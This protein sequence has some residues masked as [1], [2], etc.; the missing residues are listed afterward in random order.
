[1]YQE[2]TYLYRHETRPDAW[3]P[4]TEGVQHSVSTQ[5]FIAAK[6]AESSVW[7]IDT[8]SFKRSWP[9]S[10]WPGGYPLYYIVKDG[11][12]LCPTC[13]NEE[14][15]RTGDPDD[16]QFFIVGQDVNYE[17]NDMWCD[18]CNTKIPAAYSCDDEGQID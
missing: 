17:D 2:I 10:A 9:S 16:G 14:F 12:L 3:Y 7:L 5:D 4:M 15:H 18:H 8:D 1:M 6:V 13:A 11:G